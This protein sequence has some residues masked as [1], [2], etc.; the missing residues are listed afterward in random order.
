[1]CRC[2]ICH[3]G[4]PDGVSL[5]RVNEKGVEG[6]WRCRS[7]L[8]SEQADKQDP[9]TIRLVNIIDPPNSNETTIRP[10]N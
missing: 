4:P 9:E 10:G 6:I 1:M 5:F 2:E 3:K 8:T 7:H